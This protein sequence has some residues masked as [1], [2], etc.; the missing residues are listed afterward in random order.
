MRPP[1]SISEVSRRTCSLL[2]SEGTLEANPTDYPPRRYAWS[3][4]SYAIF[5]FVV[6]P[7]Y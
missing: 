6:A 1:E 2:Q 5:L 7:M 3:M 4:S